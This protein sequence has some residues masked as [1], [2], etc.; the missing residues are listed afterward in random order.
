MSTA[1]LDAV[2]L[3][4]NYGR[5]GG[6]GRGVTSHSYHPYSPTPPLNSPLD[7][8]LEKALRK[9]WSSYSILLRLWCLKNVNVNVLSFY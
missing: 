9:V 7:L 6:Q 1:K 5:S 8:F 3:K 4:Y 2:L